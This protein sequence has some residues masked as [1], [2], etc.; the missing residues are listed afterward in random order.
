MSVVKPKP[1][2]FTTQPILNRS[3]TETNVIALLLSTLKLT[4]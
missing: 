2:Q 4:N 3:K 1:N